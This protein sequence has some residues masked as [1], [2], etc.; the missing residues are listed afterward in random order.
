EMHGKR[1]GGI[2]S[3][4]IGGGESAAGAVGNRGCDASADEGNGRLDSHQCPRPRRRAREAKRAAGPSET[5]L[6]RI[7]QLIAM[8]APIILTHRFCVHRGAARVSNKGQSLLSIV[9]R[10]EPDRK[11]R[12][13]G[14]RTC[15]WRSMDFSLTAV[16]R[17]TSFCASA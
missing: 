8:A 5:R 16:G 14:E 6:V 2:R 10:D 3:R 17:V 7:A 13:I 15:F 1:R 4:S 9:R 12:R 11:A